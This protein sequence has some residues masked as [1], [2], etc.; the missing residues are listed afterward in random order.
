MNPYVIAWIALHG[1]GVLLSGYLAFEA[2]FDLRALAGLSNGRRKRTWARLATECI[3]FA[4]HAAGLFIGVLALRG[5][6]SGDVLVP[7]LVGQA[8][9]LIVNSLLQ[10][11][12]TRLEPSADSLAKAAAIDLLATAEEAAERIVEVA[13]VAAAELRRI[14]V[15]R[16]MERTAAAAERAADNAERTADNTERIAANT[17]PDAGS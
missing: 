8:A 17:D 3:R 9:G 10:V 5:E 1:A 12:K 4:I 13:R 2:G 11:Y 7:V 6:L 15:Q 16:G 14:E